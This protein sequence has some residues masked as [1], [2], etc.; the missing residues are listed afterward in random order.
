[1]KIKNRK[2]IFDQMV[3]DSVE[4]KK[5]HLEIDEDEFCVRIPMERGPTQLKDV[6]V[7][8]NSR[9]NKWIEMIVLEATNKAL[10]RKRQWLL[11]GKS[12][13]KWAWLP[14]FNRRNQ[15]VRVS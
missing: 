1:M 2:T 3:E 5:T 15:E 4:L 12:L 13:K 6:M 8:Y 9:E 11:A 14:L 10:N 7:I